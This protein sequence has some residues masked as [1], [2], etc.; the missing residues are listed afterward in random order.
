MKRATLKLRARGQLTIPKDW[1]EE[2]GATEGDVFV[3]RYK[4]VERPRLILELQKGPEIH[5]ADA[6]EKFVIADL[7]AAGLSSE[8]IK[9]QLPK[10]KARVEEAYAKYLQEL[11]QDEEFVKGTDWMKE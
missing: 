7:K 10:R 8:E 11:E 4:N 5:F 3:A 9:Q 2:M 6:L 1:L